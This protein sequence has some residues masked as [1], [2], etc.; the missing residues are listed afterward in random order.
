MFYM[1]RILIFCILLLVLILL[2]RFYPKQFSKYRRVFCIIFVFIL[3]TVSVIFPIEKSILK[4]SSV[5]NLCQYRY[6]SSIDYMIEGKNSCM[7]LY[8][9]NKST[10]SITFCAKKDGYQIG[11]YFLQN[12]IYNGMWNGYSFRIYQY[13]N[14]DYYVLIS[15]FSD[16]ETFIITDKYGSIFSN[17]YD[18]SST[19]NYIR[20]GAFV[21]NLDES[22]YS[23]VINETEIQ[24]LGQ[25]GDGSLIVTK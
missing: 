17:L 21:P 13:G 19:D 18:N 14:E 11:N 10:T 15:G 4:F 24:V 9:A 12:T 5:D 7:L 8:S 16:N 6:H 23:V 25:S 20:Y 1:F 3:L 2:F 22:N